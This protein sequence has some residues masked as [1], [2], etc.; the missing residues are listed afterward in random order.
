MGE[1]DDTQELEEKVLQG[2]I[3]VENAEQAANKTIT[4]E[5]Q[6]DDNYSDDVM[7]F[8]KQVATDP[9]PTNK[10]NDVINTANKTLR[11]GQSKD[12]LMAFIN[13]VSISKTRQLA[14]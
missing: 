11:E 13:N 4:E 12:P 14:T 9:L 1:R 3:D 5:D 10:H 6:D 8:L 7:K 2:I